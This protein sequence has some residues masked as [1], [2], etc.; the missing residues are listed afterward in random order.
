M[1][2]WGERRVAEEWSDPRRNLRDQ[3]RRA[4]HRGYR[5]MAGGSR[6]FPR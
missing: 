6:R 1:A 3:V 4:V 2:L 5:L